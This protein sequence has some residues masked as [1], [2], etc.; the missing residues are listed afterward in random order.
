V[1]RVRTA[2]DL[3]RLSTFDDQELDTAAN[4]FATVCP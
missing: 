4:R 2:A 3:D 1:A